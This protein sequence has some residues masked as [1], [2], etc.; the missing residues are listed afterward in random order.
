MLSTFLFDGIQSSTKA[1]TAADFV[2]VVLIATAAFLS[3]CVL[4]NQRLS[5]VFSKYIHP[6][7]FCYCCLVVDTRQHVYN[8]CTSTKHGK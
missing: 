7:L 2:V 5:S 4:Y 6:M 1:A 3:F 8:T